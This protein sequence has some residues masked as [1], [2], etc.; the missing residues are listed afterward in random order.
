VG[1]QRDVLAGDTTGHADL[2]TLSGRPRLYALGP[3]E[4][5][6]GEVTIFAGVPSVATVVEGRPTVASDHRACFLEC[7]RLA[8]GA[9]LGFPEEE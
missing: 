8:A 6:R 1:A 2:R 5:C 7:V 3:L 9:R 4:G